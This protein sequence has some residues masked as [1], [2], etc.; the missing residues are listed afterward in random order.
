MGER[1]A[2][3]L[4]GQWADNGKDQGME[5]GHS[6]SV[7]RMI[8]MVI[9]RLKNGFTA[10][11]LGC[12]NGW[13]SRRIKDIPNCKKSYGVDGSRRMIEKAIKIDPEGYYQHG[14]IPSWTPSETVDLVLSMEFIYYLEDPLNFLRNLHNHWVSPGGSVVIGLDHYS[15]NESS[16]TWPDSL[17]VHMTTLSMHE[18]KTGLLDAGFR[19]VVT[20]QVCPKEDWP[21]TLVLMG[22]KS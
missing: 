3:R 8:T 1:R 14:E 18:W 2:I 20:K 9:E 11:D 7:D 19:M 13:A 16:L 17:G 12:G 4:F 15:E 21:G 10:I 6:A 22:T 5:K